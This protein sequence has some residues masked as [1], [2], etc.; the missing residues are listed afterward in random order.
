MFDVVL[1]NEYI[2]DI[3]GTSEGTQIKFYK[4]GFWYKM[5]SNGGEGIAEELASTVLSFSSLTE[6]EYVSYESGLINQKS[7]CRSRNFLAD[8]EEFITLYRFYQVMTGEKLNEKIN[9]LYTPKERADYVLSFFQD[10]LDLDLTSYFAK[11]FTLDYIILNEDRHFNN[12]GIIRSADGTYRKAPIF[13]NGK[14]LLIGNPS[15]NRNFTIEE[16]V[17]RTIARPFSG[18]FQKN[19]ELFGSGFDLDIDNCIFQISQYPDCKEKE[20]LLYQLE[21][22]GVLFHK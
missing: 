14:S 15:V 16:N 7:G 5:D 1:G 3:D 10:A 17:K 4:D 2:A 19:W 9:I 22:C 20:I 8:D 18:S 11:I 21:N 13:D 12:L 6:E